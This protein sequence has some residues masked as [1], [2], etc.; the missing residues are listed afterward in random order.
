MLSFVS[1]VGS[2]E[3]KGVLDGCLQVWLPPFIHAVL[4]CDEKDHLHHFMDSYL[5]SIETAIITAKAPL[6]EEDVLDALT[7][8]GGG[9][10][11]ELVDEADAQD[12]GL[13]DQHGDRN[14]VPIGFVFSTV[15]QAETVMA[16]LRG[17]A[18]ER[19]GTYLYI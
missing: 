10:D 7:D 8:G 13:E 16:F 2:S 14:D 4:H 5:H 6:E 19:N 9:D 11:A 1:T 17:R 18:S 15:D 12:G 3:R